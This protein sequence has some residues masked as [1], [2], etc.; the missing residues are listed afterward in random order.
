MPKFIISKKYIS[1]FEQNTFLISNKILLVS[2][3]NIPNFEKNIPNFEKIFLISKKYIPNI[4]NILNF[5]K[6][7][8]IS[9]KILLISKRF[10]YKDETFEVSLNNEV[11]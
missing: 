7:F 8:L 11:N 9:N 2:K 5:E 3:K 1:N 4:Q 6:I 10:R